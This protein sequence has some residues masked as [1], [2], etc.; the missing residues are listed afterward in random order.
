MLIAVPAATAVAG[1]IRFAL[2]KYLASPLYRGRRRLMVG[3]EDPY[4][5]SLDP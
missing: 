2:G 3:D 5:R 4:E 1:L